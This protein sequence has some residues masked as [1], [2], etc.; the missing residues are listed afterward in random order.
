MSLEDKIKRRSFLKKTVSWLGA[1]ALTSWL[2]AGIACKSPDGTTPPP[3]K[4]VKILTTLVADYDF[5]K[6]GANGDLIYT[7]SDGSVIRD[8]LT[9]LTYAIGEEAFLGEIAENFSRN[10]NITVN[11]NGALKQ[12]SNKVALQGTKS[13]KTKVLELA[14]FNIDGLI[15]HWLFD[16]MNK[17]WNQENITV[18]FNPDPATGLRLPDDYIT[19]TEKAV[20]E[21]KGYSED[22]LMEKYGFFG[23]ANTLE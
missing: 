11:A 16:N 14:D 12:I 7:A 13:L 4:K 20:N 10:F 9:S 6:T 3:T 19:E 8:N 2:G 21:I 15:T 22:L 23:I 5:A 1:A 18:I 17:I